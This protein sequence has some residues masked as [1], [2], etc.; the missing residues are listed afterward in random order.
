MPGLRPPG[1]STTNAL[2]REIPTTPIQPDGAFNCG[3]TNRV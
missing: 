3:R 1:R 2:H